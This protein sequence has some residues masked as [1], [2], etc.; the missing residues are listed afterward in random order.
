MDSNVKDNYLILDSSF[1][2]GFF[3]S[4]VGQTEKNLREKNRR[5]KQKEKERRAK[6]EH[7]RIEYHI[8]GNE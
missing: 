6:G 1:E 2:A 7:N 3:W 4:N 8:V 5:K